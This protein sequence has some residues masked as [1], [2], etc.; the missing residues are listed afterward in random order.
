MARSGA[1]WA[2][3]FSSQ[4]LAA[5][6]SQ[7]CLVWPSWGVMNSGRKRDGLRVAGGDEDRRDRAM[8]IGFVAAFVF[9]TGAVGAVDFL[10]RVIPGAIQG[11]E[12]LVLEGAPALQVAG[13]AQTL[14]HLIIAGKEFFGRDRIEHLPD[15]VVTRDS[16]QMEQALGIALTL[17]LLHGLSGG[18]GRRDIG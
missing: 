10:R 11:D 4:R 7:S 5:A 16:L 6:I 14:Q 3:F 12:Q 9:Q 2:A 15:V 18:P 13:L 8:V 1:Y 17:G